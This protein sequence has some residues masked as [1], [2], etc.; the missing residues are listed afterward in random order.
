MKRYVALAGRVVGKRYQPIVISSLRRNANETDKY[1]PTT[2]VSPGLF[3]TPIVDKLWQQRAASGSANIG[4]PISGRPP[5]WSRTEVVYQ[6]PK[7]PVLRE[8]YS[9]PWG[10]IRVGRVFEDLDALAGNIAAA[11]CKGSETPLILVTASVDQIKMYSRGSLKEDM[12]LSGAV[13]WV[14]SSSMQIDMKAN[15]G[16]NPDP[17]LVNIFKNIFF[18]I[19][20]YDLFFFSTIYCFFLRQR[21]L[22]LLLDQRK[23]K[24]QLLLH[25]Y[26]LRLK[27]NFACSKN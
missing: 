1:T 13:S 14:G 19:W 9:N 6:F 7:D 15:S 27:K 11:H 20:Q 22:F 2:G 16:E 8:Q 23:L 17:W 25:L 18:H 5:S 3:H 10:Y 12:K 4:D 24:K 26:Y 21:V